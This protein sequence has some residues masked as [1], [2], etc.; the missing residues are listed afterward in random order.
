MDDKPFFDTNV[1]LYAFR[2]DDTRG[3]VAEICWPLEEPYPF[4]F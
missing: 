4:R 1:I 2:E 3:Q